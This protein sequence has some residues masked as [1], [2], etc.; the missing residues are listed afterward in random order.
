MHTNIPVRVD[1]FHD[2]D[3]PSLA[4]AL[5]KFELMPG[6]TDSRKARV[7][8]AV[9]TLGRLLHK[10]PT[11]I[12]MQPTF[13][14]Q[15]FRKFKHCPTGLTPKS[16]ANCKTEIRYLVRKV[17]GRGTRSGFRPLSADWVRRRELIADEPVR[18]KLSRFMA[19]CSAA[20]IEPDNVDDGTM[21]QF[22]IAVHESGEMARPEG[23]VRITI[24]TWNQL[25]AAEPRWPQVT[26]FLPERRINRWTIEPQKFPE[27]FRENVDRWQNK[28][29][30]IDPEAE[31]G[32]IRPLR[33]E[34][35]RLHRHQV[36]KAASALVFTGTPIETVTTL[37]CLVDLEAF[38][39]I[40][41]HLRERQGGEP[42]TALL[43]LA[44]T[45]KAIAKHEVRV[46]DQDVARMA[47]I[48]AN[49]SVDL[50]GHEPKTRKR[51][52]VF[53]DDRML[54]AL[55]HM[56]DR[57]LDEAEKPRTP[58]TTRRLLA[59]IA[60]AI[61]IEWHAPLRLSNLVALNLQRNIQVIRH[62]GETRWII[63]FDRHETKN[64]ALLVYELPADVVRKIEYAF[65]FYEQTN[66]WLFPG[67]GNSHKQ[68]TLLGAQVK[69]EVERR[70]GKS[71]NIHLFRGLNAT[72]QVKEN[73]N[74]MEAGRAML[75]DRSDSVI[76]R[77]YTPTAERHLIAKG[78]ETIQR[79]RIRT[80]PLVSSRAR[81]KTKAP[82]AK[83]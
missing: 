26:L 56:P 33:P 49:Y 35:L 57:L 11:E 52:D 23:H 3:M 31:E 20:G 40:L 17:C 76:R 51:L 5:A 37:A 9:T 47:R 18:W 30:K 46:S 64:R 67:N 14:K 74:G 60:V 32:R 8:S 44:W 80:A 77:F 22:R 73:D 61:E 21:E 79:V 16:L 50:E 42:T 27:S 59:Q 36:F 63:R 65:T 81:G 4:E 69:R 24:Q 83:L 13:L 10:P 45:L 72:T 66:G 25:S 71:F 39:K 15:W 12:S 55:L 58:P 62:K 82:E 43:G 75:G 34:S 41:A 68:P 2:P 6:E 48:C 19:F 70:L 1:P 7:R 53:E 29:S 54:A 78:Q 38:K 28:L